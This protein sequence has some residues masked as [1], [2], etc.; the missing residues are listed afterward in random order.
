M[1][2]ASDVCQC[3]VVVGKDNQSRS[4]KEIGLVHSLIQTLS[5]YK[6]FNLELWF[7]FESIGQCA[8]KL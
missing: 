3:L 4:F 2:Y 6:D 7:G 1:K 5:E 8:I